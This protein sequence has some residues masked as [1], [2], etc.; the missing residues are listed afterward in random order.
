MGRTPLGTALLEIDFQPWI[1]QMAHDSTVPGPARALREQMR[2]AGADVIPTRY[3]ST[4][5][6]DP[7]RSD[8]EGPGARF[9]RALG[10]EPG[11]AVVTKHGRDIFENP[12]LDALL[13]ARRIRALVISGLLTDGGVLAS[14]LSALQRGL[15]VQVAAR[16]CAGSSLEQHE[17]ALATMAAAGAVVLSP[18]IST[19]AGLRWSALQ[20]LA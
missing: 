2:T 14:A 16:A 10:A 17:L 1:L 6:G 11:D 15:A 13:Q 19:H 18:P 7:L 3:L 5:P 9:L 20:N 12:E 8:P 4:D